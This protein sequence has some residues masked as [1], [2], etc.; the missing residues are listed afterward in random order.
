MN[1]ISVPSFG[2]CFFAH[3]PKTAQ[4]APQGSAELDTQVLVLTL[5]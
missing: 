3:S 4:M 5:R 2:V 1:Y